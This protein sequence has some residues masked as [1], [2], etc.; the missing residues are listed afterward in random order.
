ME[1]G[2]RPKAVA[3]DDRTLKVAVVALGAFHLFEGWW[4]LIAP[5]S[6]F[7][8][9][10]RYGVE[11]THY[12]G[13]VGA[14]VAA[15]GAGLLLAAGRPSWRAPLLAAGALWYG[16]HALNHLF[17]VDQARSDARG[18]ADTVLLAIGTGLLAWLAVVCDRAARHRSGS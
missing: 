14:F 10:G 16:L 5:G 17:D 13:D 18:I 9:V 7:D 4:Q 11:N 12:V 1:S 6:F 15:Y 3:L 2:S 8:E